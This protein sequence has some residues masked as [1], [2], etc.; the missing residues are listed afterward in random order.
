MVYISR[1]GIV[2]PYYPLQD[3]SFLP[4]SNGLSLTFSSLSGPCVRCVL[5]PYVFFRFWIRL[6]CIF[7]DQTRGGSRR[8]FKSRFGHTTLYRD[9]SVVRQ[10]SQTPAPDPKSGPRISITILI[11]DHFPRTSVFPSFHVLGSITTRPFS[12][13]FSLIKD[14]GE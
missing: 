5:C 6:L 11:M 3:H 13:L 9:S 4:L 10:E 7:R 8:T 14:Y 1:I 12:T 2:V